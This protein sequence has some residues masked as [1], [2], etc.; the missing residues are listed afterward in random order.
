MANDFPHAVQQALE[1][2]ATQRGLKLRKETHYDAANRELHWFES[3]R[4]HRLDF[5]LDRE[6]PLITV[7]HYVDEFPKLLPKA[8]LIWCHNFIPLFP[9]CAKIKWQ[10]LTEL[11]LDLSL[12]EYKQKLS[13]CFRELS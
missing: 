12:D 7:T 5:N 8:F 11:S 9:Y 10:R 1:E 4:L 13:S 3:N 2:L 6:K